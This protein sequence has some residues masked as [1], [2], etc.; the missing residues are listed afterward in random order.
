MLTNLAEPDPS[1]LIKLPN[2]V[3]GQCYV[4]DCFLWFMARH[5]YTLQ[6]SRAQ[7]DFD[8]IE[9]TIAAFEAYETALFAQ[10]LRGAGENTSPAT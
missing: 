2:S 7:Q 8:S 9:A 5:G 6:R 4:I 1:A 10:M 3:E